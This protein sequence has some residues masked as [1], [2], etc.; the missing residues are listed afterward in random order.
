M[1]KLEC[2]FYKKNLN[3]IIVSK[4]DAQLKIA[5]LNIVLLHVKRNITFLFVGLKEIMLRKITKVKT[6]Y[7]KMK[8]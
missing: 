1:F 8:L 7:L 4:L 2:K 5:R 3:A 6:M